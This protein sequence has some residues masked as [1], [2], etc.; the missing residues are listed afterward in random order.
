MMRRLH[1]ALPK[2]MR[3]GHADDV[4]ALIPVVMS[5]LR[6][7]DVIAVKGSH[8]SRMDLLVDALLALSGKHA[9]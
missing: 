8:A 1:D 6:A 3:G 5:A 4:K 7:G 9:A 2:E